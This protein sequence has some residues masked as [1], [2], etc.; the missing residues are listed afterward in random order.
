MNQPM[1]PVKYAVLFEH[2]IEQ[3]ERTSE[4]KGVKRNKNVNL[5]VSENKS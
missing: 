4:S 1:K 2:I 5:I 3:E